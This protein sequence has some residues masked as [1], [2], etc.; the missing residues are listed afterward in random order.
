MTFGV[1]VHFY[2]RVLLVSK[3]KA[4]SLPGH[5]SRDSCLQ[6]HVVDHGRQQ[7]WP[8]YG[9]VPTCWCGNIWRPTSVVVW[10]SNLPFLFTVNSTKKEKL[11]L[12]VGRGI[13]PKDGWK[14]MCMACLPILIW[15][16]CTRQYKMLVFIMTW[17][18]SNETNGNMPPCGPYWVMTPPRPERRENHIHP[19][20]SCSWL[21]ARFFKPGK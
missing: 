19:P 10:Q 14:S 6:Q 17:P 5:D 11:R 2:R 12:Q 20:P 4:N 9:W 7:C 13:F 16:D 1:L 18:K 8:R 3:N 15:K 21:Y